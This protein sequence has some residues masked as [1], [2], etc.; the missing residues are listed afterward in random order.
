MRL[1]AAIDLPEPI[2]ETLAGLV[3]RLRPSAK[4]AWSPPSNFHI[5]TKFFGHWP[6]ERLGEL[7]EVLRGLP[8][9][10]PVEISV[11]GLGFFPNP[12]SPRV[13]WAGISAAEDLAILA[14]D[15]D[16]AAASLGFERETRKYS[17][18]L[19]LARIRDPIP[20][21][22]LHKAISGLNST[23]FG[24]FVADRHYLYLSQPGRGGSVYTKLSEYP[25][26]RS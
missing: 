13:F 16:E 4:I 2:I 10:E 18:H 15:T 23:R 12:R 26:E 5:T 3:E 6:D 1:F 17:P 24:E 7:E 22:R 14:R 21:E 19:T 8:P 25:F 20:L 11:E 9:R